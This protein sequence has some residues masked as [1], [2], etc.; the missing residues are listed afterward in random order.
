MRLEGPNSEHF[1]FF[2]TYEWSH[3]ARVLHYTRLERLDMGKQYSLMGQ[4]ISYD[5]NEVV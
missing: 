5:K 2:A 4:F 1:I 3:K